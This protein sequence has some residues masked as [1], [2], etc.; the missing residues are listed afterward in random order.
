M[1][2]IDDLKH[3]GMIFKGASAEGRAFDAFNKSLARADGAIPVK[4]RELISL[5]VALTTQCPYC[6]DGHSSSALKAGATKEELSE[7]VFI[8]A[9]LRAGGAIAHGALVAKKIKEIGAA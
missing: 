2:Q 1:Y 3:L 5:A 4:Y 6:I 8:T 9:G 7:V